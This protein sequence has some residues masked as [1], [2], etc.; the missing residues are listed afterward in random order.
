MTSPVEASNFDTPTLTFGDVGE[1]TEQEVPGYSMANAHGVGEFTSTKMLERA[2]LVDSIQWTIGSTPDLFFLGD[3]DLFLRAYP[4]NW[5]VL[6]QFQQ[7]RAGIEVT[8]RLNT[9][10]FYY[11]AMMVVMWPGN[12]VGHDL[13]DQSVIQPVMIS[14]SSAESIVKTWNYGW[15]FAWKSTTDNTN[16]VWLSMRNVFPLTGSTPDLPDAITVQIWARF[17]DVELCYP[18]LL[19]A[20]PPVFKK[21]KQSSPN[22]KWR[23][24]Q[25]SFEA[26]SEG[27]RLKIKRPKKKLGN[28]PVDSTPDLYT[29]VTSAITTVAADTIS[30]LG[31]LV[32]GGILEYA[33]G[34]LALLDK[35]DDT[36]VQMPIMKESCKDMFAC[37]IEDSNTCVSLYK[38]RYADP[39]K[40]RMPL[41]DAWTV[42]KYA[43]IPCM[44]ALWTFT[45]TT[46]TITVDLIG[47]FL[48][49]FL[50]T[51]L[52][53]AFL[54]A[55]QWR[56]SIKIMFQ[57]FTSSFVSARFVL[58]Y[59]NNLEF[60][61]Y[62]SDYTNGIARVMN[63][64]GDTVECVTLPWMSAS[65]WTS[66][67]TPQIKLYL[68]STI[69]STDPSVDAKIYCAMW[70]AGGED[71]QFAFPRQVQPNEWPYRVP[72]TFEAQ[73]DIQAMFQGEFTPIAENCMFDIDNG[74]CT[75]ESLGLITD[76]C[77]R[78]S[79][80]KGGTFDP[81]IIDGGCLDNFY[82]RPQAGV[83]YG[84]WQAFR[85][86]YFGSWRAAFIYRSGGYRW[87]YFPPVEGGLWQIQSSTSDISNGTKYVPSQDDGISRLTVPQLMVN[88]FG[89]L[90]VPNTQVSIV[91]Q[92]DSDTHTFFAAR[93]DIQLGFPILPTGYPEDFTMASSAVEK[94]P[95]VKFEGVRK[96]RLE[97][98]M[99]SAL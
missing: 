88:P 78:Y 56:G 64:K 13:D 84:T 92:G 27:G 82:D 63:V 1:T 20:T 43:Q 10:Q 3:M 5:A 31:Q 32:S 36:R 95:K 76:I 15:P 51:P 89:M 11:G 33:A 42:S 39:G 91:W 12:S 68:D 50:R 38:S 60:P 90:G 35:P 96:D 61:G 41:T 4:R 62:E 8:I 83:Q 74:L 24:Y 7:F 34:A 58:Q 85:S 73:A 72:P 70:V 59:I 37:D 52:D 29:E 25:D 48:A 79:E 6:R 17:V 69:A 71:I 2:V 93:D 46:P 28:H 19:T 22:R 9:N 99:S 44:K 55:H 54:N 80:M 81:L 16:P 97:K 66:R 45:T 40:S 23:V 14:A 94:L 86:S 30:G 21:Y 49:D 75:G 77:K 87:R 98:R 67:R 53:Y 65:W 47:A 57:F 26:Q 18:R